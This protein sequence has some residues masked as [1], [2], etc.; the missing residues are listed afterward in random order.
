M[1]KQEEI[2]LSKCKNPKETRFC[3]Q[4]RKNGKCQMD[5]RDTQCVF[6]DNE[7]MKFGNNSTIFAGGRHR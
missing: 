6:W 2:R 5:L 4:K 7:G 1:T 3:Q